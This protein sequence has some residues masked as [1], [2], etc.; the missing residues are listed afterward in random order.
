MRS[1]SPSFPE[2]ESEDGPI[3]STL[4]VPTET[5]AAGLIESLL[6]SST[7]TP[8]ECTSEMVTPN[9]VTTVS[10]HPTN[11]PGTEFL[12]SES[13][14]TTTDFASGSGVLPDTENVSLL[15]PEDGAEELTSTF[16][17]LG[18]TKPVCKSATSGTDT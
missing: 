13:D 2:E 15:V 17:I 3:S 16:P 12:M 18:T 7:V 4:L 1:L 8:Q 14:P 10:T 6:S 9:L 11:F 5:A